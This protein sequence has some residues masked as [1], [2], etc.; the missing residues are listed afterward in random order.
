MDGNSRVQSWFHQV[1][2]RGDHTND[3]SSVQHSLRWIICWT[4][5]KKKEVWNVNGAVEEKVPTY[6]MKKAHALLCHNN[7]NE[8]DTQTTAWNAAAVSMQMDSKSMRS[9]TFYMSNM[10]EGSSLRQLSA[11]TMTWWHHFDST[12][13][14]IYPKIW[15]YHCGWNCVRLLLYANG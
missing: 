8:N 13:H 15:A 10:Y 3:W 7:N 2:Q 1:Y 5:P 12:S 11:S 9:N 4:I 14:H 6:N